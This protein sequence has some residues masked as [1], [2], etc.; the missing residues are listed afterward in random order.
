MAL[1]IRPA[2]AEEMEEFNRVVRT[3]FV[4]PA[5]HTVKMPVEWTL[6][7]FDDGRLATSYAAWPLTMQLDGASASVAGVT[8]VGTLP[9]YRRRGYLRKVTEAH[10]NL[11]HERG[12]QPI[13]AL[14]ASMAAIYQRYDYAVVSTRN[15]Y[16]TEPR[17]LRFSSAR[18]VSGEFHEANDG[19][20]SL[21]LEL[22]H[23]FGVPKTGYLH[24]NE[25]M[26]AAPGTPFT[27]LTFP[28]S[29]GL[30]A[31]VVYREAGEPLGY[32]IYSVERDD[33]PGRSMGQRLIIRDLIWLTAST[34]QAIWE[35]LANMDLV[36]EISWGRVPS[37]DPLPHILLEPRML[38]MTSG[39]GMMGRIIDVEKAL[40]RRHYSEEGILAFEIIDDMC[41]W[42]SGRWR[43]EVSAAGAD[44]GRTNKEPQL[45]MPV[46]TLAMLVFGQISPT[47]AARMAR[48]DVNDNGALSIWDKVMSTA[49]RPFCADMF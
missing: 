47:E 22:Y 15:S 19:D 42:N 39:D 44:I 24:R 11:L 28:P 43:M 45:V 16:T 17:Y 12:E 49:Y 25:A 18:T 21:L 29:P 33:R 27:V 30:V 37:D 3:A 14:N 6:C 13:A 32:V 36:N 35:Y 20:M 46:S 4:S 31:R 2:K 38:N 1:E 7:A 41:P 34:Y 10:F 9:I 26:E 5:E 23:R 8:M 40:P 48:L